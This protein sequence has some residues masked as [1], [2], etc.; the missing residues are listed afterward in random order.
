MLPQTLLHLDAGQAVAVDAVS[1]VALDR[2]GVSALDDTLCSFGTA[3]IFGLDEPAFVVRFVPS[4]GF[5]VRFEISLETGSVFGCLVPNLLERYLEEQDTVVVLLNEAFEFRIFVLQVLVR[6]RFHIGITHVC[7]QVVLGTGLADEAL[8]GFFGALVAFDLTLYLRTH[9][10]ERLDA[11]LV[12]LEDDMPA[13]LRTDR[14]ADSTVAETES[15]IF[16]G[17]D[18]HALAEP[19]EVT[20]ASTAAAVLGFDTCYVG[21]VLRRYDCSDGV[22]EGFLDVV[23]AVCRHHL[24][25]MGCFDFLMIALLF[26]EHD[27]KTVLRAEDLADLTDLGVIDGLFE[28]IDIAERSDPTQ[29]TASLLYVRVG[30]N[31]TCYSGEVLYRL[32]Y[33]LG[34]FAFAFEHLFAY[35][36]TDEGVVDQVHRAIHLLRRSGCGTLDG[37]MCCTTVFGD[38]APTHLDQTVHGGLVLQ[39]LRRSLCAVAL[40]FF[41][42]TLGGVDTLCFGF[43]YFEFEIDEHVEVLVHG[44]GVECTGLVVLLIDVQ[45]LICADVF[46]VDGH[47]RLILGKSHDTHSH[48]T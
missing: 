7:R 45:K 34:T 31:L 42:E 3:G 25:D 20:S 47:Q 29:L 8:V 48:C 38:M 17:L 36:H 13:V 41:L 9:A 44:L 5:L 18:H 35:R 6:I 37:D 22:D 11:A 14:S 19:T 1:D 4:V 28:R 10:V 15:G 27:M 26:H 12:L 30:A 21:E 2:V 46:S 32:T 16:E 40:E 33:H 39:V 43:R 24:H 23:E